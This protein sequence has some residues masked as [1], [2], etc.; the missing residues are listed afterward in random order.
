[1]SAMNFGQKSFT[2]RAPAKG[3]FPIDHDGECKESMDLYMKCLRKNRFQN[4]ECREEAKCY[5]QCRMDHELMAKEPLSKL[6]YADLQDK[7][8]TGKEKS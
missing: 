3:S 1:M 2:P 6:G 8:S 7:H 4:S 5:M